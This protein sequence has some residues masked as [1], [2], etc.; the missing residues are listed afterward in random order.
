MGPA[1]SSSGGQLLGAEVGQI[2]RPQHLVSLPIDLSKS[3]T[4]VG[5][6]WPIAQ[7][8]LGLREGLRRLMGMNEDIHFA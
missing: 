1:T 6:G 4:D 2:G 5:P 7:D 3:H 8:F